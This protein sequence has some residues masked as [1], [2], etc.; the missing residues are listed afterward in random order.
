MMVMAVT[1]K[2]LATQIQH[3]TTVLELWA[4]WCGPCKIM[5]Q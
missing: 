3:G 4:P 2:T 1:R 5:S